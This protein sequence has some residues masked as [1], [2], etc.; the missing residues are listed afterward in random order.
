VGTH[1]G[2]FLGGGDDWRVAR[3]GSQLFPIFS[4]VGGE[5]QGFSGFGGSSYGGGRSWGNC[6]GRQVGAGGGVMAGRWRDLELRTT[7]RFCRSKVSLR[8]GVIVETT[9]M[10]RRVSVA[11][12][13]TDSHLIPWFF[14]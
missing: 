6:S 7:A 8:R 9:G 10:M 2:W 13:I 1:L 5:F 14:I 3:E 12:T 11:D 4:G